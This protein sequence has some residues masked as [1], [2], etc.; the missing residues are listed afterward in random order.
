MKNNFKIKVIIIFVFLFL[1][2][3]SVFAATLDV[4]VDKPNLDQGDIFTATIS[5][6]TEGQSINT[7]TGYLKYNG[8]Y[9]QAETVNIGN[10]FVNF[11]MEKPNIETN[12]Y[13]YFS[14]IT[15]GGV[16]A[17]QL[18][19]F[20]VIFQTQN[21]VGDTNISLNNINLY[22]ND[23]MG[24]VVS[25]L[26]KNATV[27]ISGNKSTNDNSLATLFN[28]KTPPEKFTITRTKDVSIFNRKWFIV[29]STVDKG[30]GVDHYQ[31]C[32]LLKCITTDSPF[33]LFNQT[34]F[35]YI[36]VKA[37]DLD[38]NMTSSMI[39]SIW[40]VLLFISVIII[41]CCL[42]VYFYVKIRR[43]LL[44]YKL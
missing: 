36:R 35:Y 29:F 10:S 12:G 42:G 33:L 44:S 2:S 6:D 13:I 9:L 16:S 8:N 32:E 37:Y 19:V 43:Y 14:G 38:G 15:P 18:E 28:N 26:I 4:N 27:I 21:N 1:F 34:P 7:I 41:I 39:V 5:L 31:V 40:F 23:G 30:S 22:L 20:K 25:P 17:N 11:W 24:S 3:K